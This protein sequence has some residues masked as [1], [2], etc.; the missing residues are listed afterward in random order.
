MNKKKKGKDPAFLMYSG[1]F[2][3]GT[4]TMNYEQR[5]KYIYL[6][7]LQ[8]QRGFL[9]DAD[10]KSVLLDTDYVL[11]EKFFKAEDGN[12]YNQKMLD[13]IE[14]RKVWTESRRKNGASGGRPKTKTK[15]N[16]NL[17]ETIKKPYG[18]YMDIISK[19]YENHTGDEDE[20]QDID[21][22]TDIQ[23]AVYSKAMLERIID[24]FINIDSRFKYNSVMREIDEDFGG[25][26]NLIEMY[27]PN[28]ISAQKNYIKQLN[29]YKDGIYG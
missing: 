9:T 24:K 29:Q 7:C 10:M 25:F 12:W 11:H 17:D 27:L 4:I 5:G 19:P 3:V 21:Q 22:N 2:I 28:D 20:D 26:Q 6:L 8:H 13:V 15:P 1:D 16:D 23:E 14:E 18:Y